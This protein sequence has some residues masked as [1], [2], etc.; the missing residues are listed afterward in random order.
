MDILK[1]YKK[2]KKISNLS[3]VSI[4]LI[5]AIW[6]NFLILNNTKFSKNLRTNLLESKL[7]NKKSDIFFEI[8]N[9][10]LILKTSK[11]IS[12]IESLSFSTAYNSEN[13]ELDKVIP[14]LNAQTTYISNTSWLSTILIEYSEINNIKSWDKILTIEINKTINK[15]E[16]LNIINANF[17]DSDSNTYELSSSSIT[18]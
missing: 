16:N 9:N 6:M 3:I 7:N 2:Y 14:K 5:I 11:N 15:T 10:N 8:S 13:I 18:F 1:K 4:S 12:N 17:T